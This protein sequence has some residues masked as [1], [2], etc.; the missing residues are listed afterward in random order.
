MIPFRAW[1]V[2]NRIVCWLYRLEQY[3]PYGTPTES[4]RQLDEA[5]V[6]LFD[7]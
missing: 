6:R 7:A 4:E 2:W 1:R 3:S 5:F